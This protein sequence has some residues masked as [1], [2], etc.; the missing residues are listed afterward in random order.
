MTDAGFDADEV[1]RLV[2]N[3]RASTNRK[4]LEKELR[5]GLN[6][7]TKDIRGQLV[8]VIPATLPKRGGLSS[9]IAESTR[10]RTTVKGGKWAGVSMVF[11]S[12]KHDIRTITGKR[13]HHPVF[14]NR[15]V[16]VEQTKGLEPEIWS[17]EL[18]QQTPEIR[19]AVERVMRDVANQVG[20]GL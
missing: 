16:W 12:R 20:R 1:E 9:M 17:A 13:L 4:D 19:R 3:I 10:S 8:K 2:K 18:D 6:R 7:E 5:R 11:S 15:E 14:G